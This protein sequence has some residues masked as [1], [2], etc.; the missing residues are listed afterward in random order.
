MPG[1][2]SQICLGGELLQIVSVAFELCLWIVFQRDSPSLTDA[3]FRGDWG[4]LKFVL[5]GVESL[6]LP[7]LGAI[8]VSE[9]VAVAFGLWAARLRVG[10]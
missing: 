3:R 6:G 1:V 5:S 4:G 7:A 9:L 8:F 2:V 10:P